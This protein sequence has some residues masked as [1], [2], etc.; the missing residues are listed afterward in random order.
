MNIITQLFGAAIITI[1]AGYTIEAP[2]HL[3]FK[4]GII[5]VVSYAANLFLQNHM[6]FSIASAYF[7]ACLLASLLSQVFAR[8]LKAPVTMFY[9]PTFYLYV[10]GSSIYQ[11]ALYYIEGNY[12]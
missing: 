3:V 6:N 11:T 5:G 4:T 7:L 8:R 1:T 9:I 2:R 12:P 10:P